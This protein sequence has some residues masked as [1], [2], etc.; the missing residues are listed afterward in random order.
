LKAVVVHGRDDV[1][2]R[3]TMISIIRSALP[4]IAVA[5][6][7]A[8]TTYDYIIVGGGLAGSVLARRLAD[9]YPSST[10]LLLEAGGRP[11]GD[12]LIGP[13]LACFASHFSDIDWAYNTI[14][15]QHLGG[16]Q[17]YQAGGGLW[18]EH[19]PAL[20]VMLADPFPQERYWAVDRP[21]TMAFGRGVPRASTTNGLI[22][23]ATPPG[24]GMLCSRTSSR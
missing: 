18:D 15:Q 23:Q 24:A 12:P 13:P 6:A 19:R 21:S 16:K 4:S 5:M 2:H 1:H 7:E 17:V 20:I 9:K 3:S 22:S 8:S 10:I 11:E 14:P